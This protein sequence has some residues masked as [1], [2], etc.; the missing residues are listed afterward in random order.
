MSCTP[1]AG[2]SDHLLY[3]PDLLPTQLN[4]STARDSCVTL[5]Q[6]GLDHA[7]LH[8]ISLVPTEASA[9]QPAT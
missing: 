6:L 4:V 7:L 5:V 1:A 2:R 3:E 8:M 9:A